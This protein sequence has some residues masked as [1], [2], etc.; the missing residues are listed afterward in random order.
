MF[1]TGGPPILRWRRH[2][3]AHHRQFAASVRVADNRRGIIGKDAGHW[4]QVTDVA[5][6]Y[7]KKRDDG[8]LVS[9]DAVEIAHY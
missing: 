2:A 4:R 5:V 3:A 6:D 7:A 9:G 8:G 1:V